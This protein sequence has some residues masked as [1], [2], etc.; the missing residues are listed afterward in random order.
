MNDF[1]ELTWLPET[2]AIELL[3]AK[4]KYSATKELFYR[5]VADNQIPIA[6]ETYG[7]QTSPFEISRKPS[8]IA[9]DRQKVIFQL[10]D[11]TH[12][13]SNGLYQLRR[14]TEQKIKEW[15][16]ECRKN[17][18]RD[19]WFPP[20]LY[21]HRD[22]KT[23][24]L[25][26]SSLPFSVRNK[27]FHGVPMTDPSDRDSRGNFA[28]TT[29]ILYI[30][31]PS[32]V[33]ENSKWQNIIHK[34][35]NDKSLD[36]FDLDDLWLIK[37]EIQQQKP[38]L[39]QGAPTIAYRLIKSPALSSYEF[40]TM[41]SRSTIKPIFSRVDISNA[42][43]TNKAA[44]KPKSIR[45][46]KLSNLEMLVYALTEMLRPANDGK[47]NVGDYIEEKISKQFHINILGGKS[48]NDLRREGQKKLEANQKETK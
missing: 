40:E 5:F 12:E 3:G 10:T 16:D 18:L 15:W 48:I 26:E 43:N 47:R 14:E 24:E 19:D 6:L 36:L 23:I 13:L 22:D 31:P 39:L 7:I 11:T 20:S 21:I 33:S 27:Q 37:P 44:K 9:Y 35:S 34:L 42:L 25:D 17:Y 38:E 1:T 32:Q 28:P 2:Q 8:F 46:D 30:L 29:E 4:L 41:E 45:D